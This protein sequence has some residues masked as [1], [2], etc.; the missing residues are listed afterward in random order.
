MRRT[1]LVLAAALVLATPLAASAREATARYVG[2]PELFRFEFNSLNLGGAEFEPRAGESRVTVDVV[3]DVAG[4]G[5]GIEVCQ[6]LASD[7]GACGDGPNEPE[8]SGCAPLV[9]EFDPADGVIGVWIGTASS[10]VVGCTLAP[11]VRGT[12]TATFE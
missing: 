6:H 3:D 12:I 5:V 8:V 7:P 2:G 4:P 11:A 10:A 1:V 9:L